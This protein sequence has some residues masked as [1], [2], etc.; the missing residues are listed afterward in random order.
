MEEKKGKHFLIDLI[1]RLSLQGLVRVETS[2]GAGTDPLL[3]G[4]EQR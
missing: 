1:L 2:Q 4:H 3:S